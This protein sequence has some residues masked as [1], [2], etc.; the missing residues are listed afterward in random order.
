M[1]SPFY[2]KDKSNLKKPVKIEQLDKIVINAPKGKA[3]GSKAL[4]DHATY[5]L[6]KTAELPKPVK[7]DNIPSRPLKTPSERIVKKSVA[8][9]IN[10]KLMKH[11]TVMPIEA[12]A[13]AKFEGAKPLVQ[14]SQRKIY[15]TFK[16]QM[17]QLKN[18]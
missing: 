13:P 3:F 18:K 5:K 12:Y 7:V 14:S 8:E 11:S 10:E 2:N 1:G 4:K 9:P 15:S 16:E 17:E 6:P